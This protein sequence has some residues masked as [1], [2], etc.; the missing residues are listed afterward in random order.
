MDDLNQCCGASPTVY[1]PM[2]WGNKQIDESLTPHVEC[3]K[4][5]RCCHGKTAGEAYDNWNSIDKLE[6]KR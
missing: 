2:W 4:C 6:N 5:G 1:M 3:G